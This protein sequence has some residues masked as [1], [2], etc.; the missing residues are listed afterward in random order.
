MM[1]SG[2]LR[3][4]AEKMGMKLDTGVIDGIA[5]YHE[6]LTRA[7]EKFNLTRIS[8]DPRESA[9]RNYLDS[10]APIAFKGLADGARTILDA[11][12]G[13]GLP[14]VPLALALKE[15]RVTMIDS[16]GKK[17]RFIRDACRQL[18]LDAQTIHA[19]LEDCAR[20][21]D[22]RE[23]FDACVCRALAPMRVLVEITLPFVVVGGVLIAYKG[24]SAMDELDAAQNAIELLGGKALPILKV[25]SP[26]DE[27]EHRLV[28]VKKVAPTPAAYPRKASIPTKNPL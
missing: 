11:G 3:S 23:K 14:G 8:A 26:A 16:S 19:R 9:F 27:W 15:C 5:R 17:V 18:E 13:A 10:L 22:L 12:S 1:L 20:K 6:L 7:N 28:V 2:Y 24:P 4:G 25:P 21:A